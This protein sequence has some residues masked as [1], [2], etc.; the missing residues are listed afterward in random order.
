MDEEK[1]LHTSAG[2]EEMEIDLLELAQDFGR[3]LRQFW[4]L[5]GLIVLVVAGALGIYTYG[6]YTPL[7]QCHATFTVAT[8]TSD[9][10]LYEYYY[11]Q[12]TADQMSKTFP[13]ILSS[14]YFNSV[15]LETLGKEQLNG[16]IT[17]ETV[18]DS[19]MVTMTVTSP[20]PDDAQT[21]LETAIEIYPETARFVL[22]TVQFH[23]INNERII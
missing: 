7:Y 15:L 4:W 12:N 8:D 19:N 9:N 21:I 11:S 10:G 23:M 2:D 6:S 1:T 17:A 22:G 18:S 20:S 13:Y 3:M 14:S 5:F 16:T